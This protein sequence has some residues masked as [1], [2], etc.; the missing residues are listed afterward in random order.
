ML[1]PYVLSALAQLKDFAMSSDQKHLIDPENIVDQLYDIALD[2]QSLD[3]FIDAWNA[4]GLDASTARQTIKTIDDFDA[5]YMAHLKRAETFLARGQDVDD[6]PDLTKMLAPFE[7]LAA[8]IIDRDMRIVASNSGAQHALGI[9][10]GT[11]LDH[12]HLPHNAQEQLLDTLGTV[13]ATNDQPDRLLRLQFSG[14]QGPALFQIRGLSERAN[15]APQYALIVTTQYHW[16][17]ALGETLEDVFKLTITEQVVVR[18][19]VE[20]KDAKAI[21]AERGTSEG[22]VRG[23]IKSILAKMNARSQSEVIRL[24]L[25]LRD[26]SQNKPETAAPSAAKSE[27]VGQDWLS[28]QVYK[29][30]ETLTL[31]DGRRM[32]YHDMGPPT[33]A[34][35][36]YTHMGY[37]LARWH[38]PMIKLAFQLGLRIIVPIRAGY[39]QSDVLDK[40]ADVLKCGREDAL[41][42]LDHLGIQKLP[43]VCQGNDLIFGVDLICHVPERVSELVGICARPCLPGDQHYSYMGK[44]HRFFLSTAKHAPHLLHFTSKAAVAMAK[45][46]G[47]LEMFRQMNQSSPSDMALL[48]DP[49]T[50]KVLIENAQLIAGKTTNIAQTYAMELLASERDWSDLLFKAKDTQTW[51]INGAEDPA[52]DMGTVAEYRETY[53]WIDI[54]VIQDAG[55]LLIYQHFEHVLPRLAEAARRAAGP[56]P[57]E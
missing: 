46:I 18:A 36:L 6:G 38:A 47:L 29:P 48:D 9:E 45:R 56:V 42:L 30:F 40:N 52:S 24:V 21:A 11:D 14:D 37:G 23:Q 51:F 27:A 17:P 28:A 41:F 49:Q 16:Q 19:L 57:P 39:G 5:A 12:F 22:T 2:P 44:W 35:I 31:P 33:G 32:D 34:P 20:G 26:V 8:F 13:F 53:P 15:A 54:E 43:Y 50:A 10:D 4:A 55:Q 1:H 7:D 25:S 3:L